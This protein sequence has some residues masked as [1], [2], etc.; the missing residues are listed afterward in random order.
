MTGSQRLAC[1]EWKIFSFVAIE[2][3]SFDECC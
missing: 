1:V 2:I 3:R